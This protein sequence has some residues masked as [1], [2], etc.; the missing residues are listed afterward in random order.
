MGF[1]GPGRRRAQSARGLAVRVSPPP[2]LRR[3]VS[4]AILARVV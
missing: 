2:R 4:P 3:N 1:E